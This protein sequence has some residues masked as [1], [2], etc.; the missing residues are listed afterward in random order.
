MTDRT[1]PNGGGKRREKLRSWSSA[2]RSGYLLTSHDISMRLLRQIR[3]QY[4]DRASFVLGYGSGDLPAIGEG[5]ELS[6]GSAAVGRKPG[7]HDLEELHD[8]VYQRRSGSARSQNPLVRAHGTP[9][10]G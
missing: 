7:A 2:T 4:G 1:R 6:S 8:A 9:A 5:Q 10:S 3:H